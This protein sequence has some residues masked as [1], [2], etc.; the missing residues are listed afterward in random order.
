VKLNTSQDVF[1]KQLLRKIE[2]RLALATL[3]A[4]TQGARVPKRQ[5]RERDGPPLPF[6]YQG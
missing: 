4:G 1:G 2:G 3:Q 5:N 6:L